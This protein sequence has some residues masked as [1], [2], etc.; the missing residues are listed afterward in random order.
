MKEERIRVFSG[1]V[2]ILAVQKRVLREANFSL[3]HTFV[4]MKDNTFKSAGDFVCILQVDTTGYET[5]FLVI[6]S[7]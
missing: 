1:C 7:P 2:I 5:I 3:S 6:V 4:I